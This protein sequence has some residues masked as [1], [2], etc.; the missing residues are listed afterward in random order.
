[1]V[2]RRGRGT[3]PKGGHLSNA[4]P[5]PPSEPGLTHLSNVAP[6]RFRHRVFAGDLWQCPDPLPRRRLQIAQQQGNDVAAEADDLPKR[7]VAGDL[8]RVGQ[9]LRR[10]FPL[11]LQSG[12][13]CSTGSGADGRGFETGPPSR[14]LPRDGVVLR[15][16][17]HFFSSNAPRPRGVRRISRRPGR[18][19]LGRPRRRTRR[20]AGDCLT[21]TGN[22]VRLLHE[23]AKVPDCDETHSADR[24]A[25]F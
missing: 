14:C 5:A 10:R 2:T 19:D 15:P 9:K 6:I 22:G 8:V 3:R 17:Y 12:S 11:R 7:G 21:I 23:T 16:S 20:P 18:I 13:R 1:M 24:T 4:L 25:A